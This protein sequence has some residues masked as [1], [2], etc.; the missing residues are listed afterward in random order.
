[1]AIRLKGCY[2]NC[3]SNDISRNTLSR[4][5]GTRN[6]NKCRLRVGR[7]R[8]LSAS[9]KSADWGPI[10]LAK[11]DKSFMSSK[12]KLVSLLELQQLTK[13]AMRNASL[14]LLNL[15][16]FN[17]KSNENIWHR[18][19]LSIHCTASTTDPRKST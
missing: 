12:L 10:E 15:R 11:L 1:M 3:V 19:V 13:T 16:E 4:T 8:L 14:G 17:C 18:T 5:T 2:L 9:G 7:D 6:V